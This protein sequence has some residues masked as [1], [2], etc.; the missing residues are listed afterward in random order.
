LPHQSVRLL[1]LTITG[2]TKVALL[3]S[4]ATLACHAAP[5]FAQDGGAAPAASEETQSAGVEQI[6]V[7]ARRREERLQDTPIS[8]T[9][10]SEAG[11]EA[12]QIQRVSGIAQQTPGFTFEEASPISGSS[13]VAVMFIRGIGQVESIPTVDL[14]VGLYVDGVYL[15]RSVGGVLD[16]VDPERV[17]VLRGP[18]GT[19]FGRNTIGGAVSITSRRPDEVFGGQISALY[20]TDNHVVLRGSI[21][22]PISDRVF[23]RTSGAYTHQD[24]YVDK[25]ANGRD[26]GDQN[27]LSLRTHLRLEATDSFNIDVIGDYTRERTNGAAYVLLDTNATGLAPVFPDGSPTPFPQ[28]SKAGLFPFFFNEVINA[29]QCG[30]VPPPPSLPVSN[31]P[32]TR[33]CF[34]QQWVSPGLDTDFSD[35]DNFSHLDIWGVSMTMEWNLGPLL[36]KSITSYRKTE[37]AY[38]IDQDHTPLLIAEV[39][40]VNNQDQFTQELQILGEAFN[41]RLNYIVGAFYF[42]ETAEISENVTFSPVD[43]ISGGDIDNDSIAFFAQG[44]F[45]L[46][47]ALSITGGIRYTKDRKRFLPVQSVGVNS[48]GIPVGLPLVNIIVNGVP[49]PAPEDR[50]TFSRWTPMVNLSY[51]VAPDVLLYASYSEGFKSG[52][53]TQRVFPPI[54]LAEGETVGD[55]LG[56]GPEIAKVIEGGFKADLFDRKVRLNGA[57]Y[58]TDYTGVQVTVQN[59]SVAPVILN[60]ASAEILGGELEAIF[61]PVS[62]AELNLAVGYIDAEYN[63]IAPGAQVEV[64]DRF[65][66]TP[67]WTL[68]GGASYQFFLGGDWSMTPRV[69]WAYRSR[70]ENDSI[71]SP[72]ISQPGFHRLDAG[73]TIAN[74]TGLAII[75]RL[76]NIT[77]ERF[78]TGAFSDDISLGLSEAVLDRGRQWSITVRQEF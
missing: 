64:A 49:V 60:A 46:T 14:G 32:Q 54:T 21:N 33:N 15:A 51:K 63:E 62:G 30:S 7:T 44:T 35:I 78:I 68:S 13:A 48:L 3:G 52:G 8:I 28:D 2:A 18:Q 59:V 29:A 38:N 12:R 17:E 4:A 36:L 19:L 24:G 72:Q 58:R 53:F 26:T 6:V 65:I 77:D 45:D 39:N 43:F 67:E 34:G 73:V 11:I 9:A 70:V 10:F 37:A 69:D 74:E 61:V 66:K 27:R 55:E 5:V 20:G 76:V 22:T 41:E 40:S 50:L 47:D 31:P 75:G 42:K 1:A 71:N 56:F 57:V 16:L 23:L 25:P